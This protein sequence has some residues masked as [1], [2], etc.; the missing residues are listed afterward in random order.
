[1]EDI[2]VPA[3]NVF[4][5]SRNTRQPRDISVAWWEEGAG[6]GGNFLKGQGGGGE[7][8]C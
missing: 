5:M 4:H 3:P 8:Q 2:E 6:E 7:A 1:M